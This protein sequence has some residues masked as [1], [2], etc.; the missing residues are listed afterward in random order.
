VAA[1]LLIFQ[2]GNRLTQNKREGPLRREAQGG[3]S[4]A[5]PKAGTGSDQ[6][7]NYCQ[8]YFK[9]LDVQALPSNHILG[10]G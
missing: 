3:A 2:R 8:I 6:L 7:I 1:V 4:L 10:V 5:S 9:K